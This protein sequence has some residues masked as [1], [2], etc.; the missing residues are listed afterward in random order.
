MSHLENYQEISSQAWLEYVQEY[1]QHWRVVREKVK[2][3]AVK[4]VE[5]K[6]QKQKVIAKQMSKL[7]DGYMKIEKVAHDKYIAKIVVAWMQECIKN[8]ETKAVNSN[9]R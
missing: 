3:L 7:S 2:E 6:K 8:A 9:E 5:A 4:Y 1:R